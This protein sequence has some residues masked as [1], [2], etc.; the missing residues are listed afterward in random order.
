MSEL[1]LQ[2]KL[3]YIRYLQCKRDGIL[4]FKL[5]VENEMELLEGEDQ[6]KNNCF[7]QRSKK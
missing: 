2:M 4:L 7:L 3:S 5:A 6:K 1:T